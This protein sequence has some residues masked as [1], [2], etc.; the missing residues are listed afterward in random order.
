MRN[1]A[2]H[3]ECE[4][5]T[6][7]HFEAVARE[8]QR[9]CRID[10]RH[11][12]EL[13]CICSLPPHFVTSFSFKFFLKINFDFLKRKEKKNCAKV[14]FVP[15]DFPRLSDLI[16]GRLMKLLRTFISWLKQTNLS[17]RFPRRSDLIKGELMNSLLY[18]SIL[19]YQKWT[20]ATRFTETVGINQGRV[21]F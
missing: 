19:T 21:F 18:I 3:R 9:G 4:C 8:L 12:I 15:R 7:C 1:E 2:T 17:H 11:E 6:K 14:Y 5:W 13:D 16:K 20:Y 10:M